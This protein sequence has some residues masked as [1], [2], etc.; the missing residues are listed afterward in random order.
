MPPRKLD[1]NFWGAYHICGTRCVIIDIL[2]SLIPACA[3]LN[4]CVRVPFCKLQLKSVQTTAEVCAD[5]T[6]SLHRLR[7]VLNFSARKCRF[8]YDVLTRIS[9]RTCECKYAYL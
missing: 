3:P 6:C 1:K 4:A 7:R 9:T 2:S 5:Y 8:Q